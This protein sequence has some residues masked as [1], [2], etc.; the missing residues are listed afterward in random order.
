MFI[1]ISPSVLLT[2]L[3]V[4]RGLHTINQVV[5]G[6]AVG[7]IFSILWF[8]SWDALVLN[9]FISSLWVRLVVVMGAAVFCL[10]FL[11]FVIGYWFKD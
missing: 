4:S 2:W 9:S 8:W 5:A 1:Y 11:V 7:S 6:A 3:R 10:A